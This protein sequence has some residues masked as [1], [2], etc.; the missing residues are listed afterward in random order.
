VIPDS[1]SFGVRP[2]A[3]VTLQTG[4]MGTSSVLVFRVFLVLQGLSRPS[5]S[6]SSFFLCLGP[7]SALE[8]LRIRSAGRLRRC[9]QRHPMGQ[10]WRH[11]LLH[12]GGD[13][14]Q[15]RLARPEEDRLPEPPVQVAQPRYLAWRHARGGAASAHV[16]L[17]NGGL[18]RVEPESIAERQRSRQ[19]NGAGQMHAASH[20][21]VSRRSATKSRLSPIV[22]MHRAPLAEIATGVRPAGPRS[23][24]RAP[25]SRSSSTR[26]SP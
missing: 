11:Q 12:R 2:E 8:S 7:G 18:G 26:G 23:G 24:R 10:R 14:S 3:W 25:V 9:D 20:L 1:C 5:G 6:F 15:G 17:L 4:H 19:R 13:A 21:D 22:A 16:Q